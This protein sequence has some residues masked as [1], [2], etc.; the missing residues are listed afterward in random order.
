MHL[1]FMT[2]FS[3]LF[4]SLFLS[5]SLSLL[6]FVSPSQSFLF[7]DE[8]MVSF[9]SSC[10]VCSWFNVWSTLTLSFFVIS[11]H[12]LYNHWSNHECSFILIVAFPSSVDQIIWGMA[13]RW[14]Y[15]YIIN[16][17]HWWAWFWLPDINAY[18]SIAGI[19]VTNMALSSKRF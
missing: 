15:K 14:C 2:C 7:V 13:F 11:Y 19:F 9:T 4:V 18:L 16:T 3:P 1:T 6:S 12:I 8:E 5:L 10:S 17:F